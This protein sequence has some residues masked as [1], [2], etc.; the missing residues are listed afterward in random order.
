MIDHKYKVFYQLCLTPSTTA[1][2]DILGLTQPAVSK[3]VRE[4]EKELG[5]TLFG[6][7]LNGMVLTESGQE[8][9]HC[10]E[11]LIAQ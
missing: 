7:T 6:R 1:A 11:P 5:I 2:A 9:I 4:L 8:L 3:N 10:M